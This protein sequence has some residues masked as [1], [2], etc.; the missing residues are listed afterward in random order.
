MSSLLT[1]VLILAAGPGGADG[2]RLAGDATAEYLAALAVEGADDAA[3]VIWD[4]SPEDVA[5]VREVP[6]RGLLIAGPPGVYRV[7][8]RV[9]SVVGGRVTVVTLRADVAITGRRGPPVTPPVVPPVKPPVVPDP[10]PPIPT[11][12]TRLIAVI[13]DDT[14]T[15]QQARGRLLSDAAVVARLRERR[16]V[17]RL[18]SKDAVGPDGR[19]PADVKPYIDRAAEKGVYPYLVLIDT[20]GAVRHE[21]ALPA[22]PADLLALMARVG[23]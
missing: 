5:A 4:V 23:G 16:H 12:Q 3:G 18:V 20:R 21:G 13:V 6:G 22:S 8:A 17:L 10:I 11:D 9:V 2:P 15:A 1:V 14:R 19:P 7:R